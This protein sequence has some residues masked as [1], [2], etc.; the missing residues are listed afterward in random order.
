MKR[1]KVWKTRLAYFFG[2][3]SWTSLPRFR[4]GRIPY[5]AAGFGSHIFLLNSTCVGSD[6]YDAGTPCALGEVYSAP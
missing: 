1:T 2:K 6:C 3:N 5:F 4:Q